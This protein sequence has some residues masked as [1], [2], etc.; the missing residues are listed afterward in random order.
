MCKH[1]HSSKFRCPMLRCCKRMAG[2]RP[3]MR[4]LDETL[5]ETLSDSC[6]HGLHECGKTQILDQSGC[7]PQGLS[8]VAIAQSVQTEATAPFKV[9]KLR[10]SGRLDNDNYFGRDSDIWL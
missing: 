10:T 5:S 4:S 7:S 6:V 9:M 3:V 8:Q 2:A 1:V